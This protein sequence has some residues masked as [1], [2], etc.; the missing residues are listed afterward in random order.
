MANFMSSE[1]LHTSQACTD[2]SAWASAWITMYTN[3]VS[4]NKTL[5]THTQCKVSYCA[6]Y[7]SHMH[8]HCCMAGL[9]EIS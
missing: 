2:A 3:T 5:S 1:T 9:P 6:C 8:M 4:P 7:D